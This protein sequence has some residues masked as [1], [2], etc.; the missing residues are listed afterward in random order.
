MSKQIMIHMGGEWYPVISPKGYK[1][2]I[3]FLKENISRYKKDFNTPYAYVHQE[4]S[5]NHDQGKL[6]AYEEILK[7][8]EK[9]GEV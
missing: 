1:E 5:W 4:D 3:N 7:Q 8:I 6:E 9:L 2:L